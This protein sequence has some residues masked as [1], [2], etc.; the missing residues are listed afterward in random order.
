MWLQEEA[1]EELND[2]NAEYSKAA[3]A[4]C[5]TD[6]AVAE[7]AAAPALQAR[8]DEAHNLAEAASTGP[9]GEAAGAPMEVEDTAC[10]VWWP[11]TCLAPRE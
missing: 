6:P 7:P 9:E 1:Q 11:S 2:A 4:A 5:R 8:D 10:A 3:E